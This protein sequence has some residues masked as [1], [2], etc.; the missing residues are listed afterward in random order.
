TFTFSASSQGA[1]G[2][3]VFRGTDLT[4]PLEASSGSSSPAGTA[5]TCNIGG[6]NSTIDPMQA[7]YLGSPGT[8]Y[9]P[10][11]GAMLVGFFSNGQDKTNI[12]PPPLITTTLTCTQDTA[13]APAWTET[14]QQKSGG[15]GAGFTLEGSYQPT[16]CGASGANCTGTRTAYATNNT[17]SADI[18]QML[19]LRPPQVLNHYYVTNNATG[20]NCQAEN[21]TITAHDSSHNPVIMSAGSTITVT[22]QY[23]AGA[24][25]AI[26]ETGRSS[27]AADRLAVARRITVWPH[28]PSRAAPVAWCSRS[29]IPG[30]RRCVSWLPTVLLPVRAARPAPTPAMPRTCHS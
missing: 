24:A 21:V 27:A 6:K 14:I 5:Q 7:P 18:A 11:A 26:A 29:R 25:A 30:C 13:G 8:Q 2:M 17:T 1:G 4:S 12:T 22:A 3:M 16:L 28:T 15:G 10:T 19:A 20:V 23:V 9:L